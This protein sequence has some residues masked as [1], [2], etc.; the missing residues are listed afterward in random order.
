MPHD[1]LTK[2]ITAKKIRLEKRK[3]ERPLSL[4]EQVARALPAPQKNFLKILRAKSTSPIPLHIIAEV[5]KASPS[6]GVI[7]EDFKPLEIAQAYA[8]G[9]ASA[10]SVLT[11]EDFFQGQD[12]YL[13]Q[14]ASSVAIPALRKDFI[15]DP[16]Q[17]F[18]A[19]CLGASAF[20]LLVN[21]LSPEML[22][23]FIALGQ[24]LGLTPLVETHTAEEIQIAL[25]AGA[26]L[27]GINN[28][29]LKTFNISLEVTFKLRTL[30]PVSIPVIS[31]SGIFTAQNMQRLVDA[32]VNAAL[33]GESLMRETNMEK[34]LREL[35]GFD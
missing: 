5:K 17:I 10:V 8:R 18:E 12:V 19:K 27:I 9:G 16:Y 3:Q 15:I 31:E 2:I 32:G 1:I 4:V 33:I 35:L 34:K 22:K 13:Q 6:K 25:D 20:L 26:N 24:E 29:D 11:E 21:C 14:I 7:R 23:N 28:R 30:I